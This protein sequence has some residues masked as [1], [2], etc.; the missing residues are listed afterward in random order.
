MYK[1]DRNRS[2]T[3]CRRHPLEAASTNIAYRKYSGQTGFEQM[4][5]TRER[6]LSGGEIFRRQ[7]WSRLD[8][9]LS[10]KSHTSVQPMCVWYCPSHNE[11]VAYIASLYV[12][13]YVIPP[14]RALKM[15]A[16]FK[17][18]DL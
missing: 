11:E 14:A 18:C 1:G 6:P 7:I 5:S 4:R 17:S 8:K 12:S 3:H 10:I 16:A 9:A 2:F 13:G 15:I